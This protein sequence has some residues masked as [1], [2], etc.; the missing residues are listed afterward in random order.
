MKQFKPFKDDLFAGFPTEGA[1]FE[2]SLSEKLG[3]LIIFNYGKLPFLQERYK[4]VIVC[5]SAPSILNKNKY[6][7]SKLPAVLDDESL[8]SDVLDC[9]EATFK[10]HGLP[11][12]LVF[13]ECGSIRRRL[14]Q[15]RIPA[16]DAS[17]LTMKFII[18]VVSLI[19]KHGW[20]FILWR[21]PFK[22][23]A[24]GLENFTFA[25][26]D[27][28]FKEL[29]PINHPDL[30]SRIHPDQGVYDVA[31]IVF[32]AL[33]GESRKYRL[34]ESDLELLKSSS[35]LDKKP[36]VIFNFNTGEYVKRSK[37]EQHFKKI[38][39]E[40]K[41]AKKVSHFTVYVSRLE[42]Y[43]PDHLKCHLDEFAQDPDVNL[44]AVE[45][46]TADFYRGASFIFSICS[47]FVHFTN[48]LSQNIVT[49]AFA[50]TENDINGKNP[51]APG[52]QMVLN[53][54]ELN[55]IS[56]QI[57]SLLRDPKRLYL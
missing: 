48:I 37:V 4:K 45:R 46:A 8:F 50:N 27:T 3:D 28:N 52:I 21:N 19:K 41:R 54:E 23:S 55:Q 53:D 1:Y 6:I 30:C 26:D 24:W 15:K 47:G 13:I 22:N 17:V 44:F 36:Y 56:Q 25:I 11:N 14:I 12:S 51:W 42:P 43:W 20:H 29:F 18:K 10:L 2:I 5:N 31:Q 57:I 32:Q 35:I 38:L 7:F 16:D 34:D 9:L 40:I 33:W 39:E 49:L